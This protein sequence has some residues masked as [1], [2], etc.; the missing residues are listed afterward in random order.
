MDGWKTFA[1]FLLGQKNAYFQARLLLVLGRVHPK[2][3]LRAGRY[4]WNWSWKLTL[5][6]SKFPHQNIWEPTGWQ[7]FHNKTPKRLYKPS[8]EGMIFETN[9]QA[10]TFKETTIRHRWY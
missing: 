5:D 7:K 8:Q 3:H 4:S 10:P 1:G 6:D 2:L 9:F